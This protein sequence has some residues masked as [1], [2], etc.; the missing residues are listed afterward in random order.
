MRRQPP[1]VECWTAAIVIDSGRYDP[2]D[3]PW[4][5]LLPPDE[6]HLIAEQPQTYIKMIGQSWRRGDGQ[7]VAQLWQVIALG[8][9]EQ[10][11]EAA[12]DAAMQLVLA[13]PQDYP[14]GRLHWGPHRLP[15]VRI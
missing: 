13:N 15:S 12:R 4:P 3:P 10:E 14:R 1:L 2:P 11:A 5:C 6:A 8:F 7:L 9:I